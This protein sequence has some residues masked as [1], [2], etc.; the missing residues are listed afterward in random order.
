MNEPDLRAGL[1]HLLQ[2]EHP[3]GRAVDGVEVMQG[4]L[5]R[6]SS[7]EVCGL[8]VSSA[9]HVLLRLREYKQT[10]ESGTVLDSEPLSLTVTQQTV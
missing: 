6:P 8:Q 1:V 5:S 9:G 4:H 3:V 7:G 2:S 10:P